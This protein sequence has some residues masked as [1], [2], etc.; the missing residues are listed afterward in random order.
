MAT[1]SAGRNPLSH[2]AAAL[3]AALALVPG[4]CSADAYRRSADREVE[5]ILAGRVKS[6]RDRRD[7]TMLF[8][9]EARNGEES[10]ASPGGE[11]RPSPVVVPAVMTIDDALSVAAQ[12]NREYVSRRESLYLSGLALS[13]ARF[14]FSPQFGAT[15]SYVS[16]DASGIEPVDTSLGTVTASQILPTGGTVSASASAGGLLDRNTNGDF[17]TGT[18]VDA[19]LEQPLLR[20]AGYEVSHE[21]LTQAQRNVVYAIRDFARF[22]ESF[23]LD[24]T[25]RYYDIL[26][27]KTVLRN[28]EERYAAVEYQVRRAKALFD[29]G[30][31]DKIEVLRAERDLLTVQNELVNARDTLGFTVDQFKVFLGLPLSARFEI[32]EA[33]PVFRKVDVSLSSAV[34][35]AMANRFDLA[36]AREQLEDAERAVRIA[37]DALLPDLSFRA[38]TAA[39]SLQV[40]SLLDHAYD[41]RANSVGLF[42]EIPLQQTL[43]RNALRSAQIS[44]DAERRSY[45]EFRDNMIVEVRET[46]RR[47][48]QAAVSLEIQANQIALSQKLYEKAQI[49]FD[50]GRIG[51]RDLLEAQQSLT[52]ARNERIQRVVQYELARI[53]LERS[54]GTL[55][56]EPDGSWRVRRAPATAGAGRD[57]K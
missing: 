42:L 31:Q 52:D 53:N 30:K 45:E 48:R 24:V 46:L 38:S 43:E 36:N 55:E 32:A 51:N 40:S 17:R 9:E 35:A 5:D 34:A 54:M 33:E 50:A 37:A 11:D 20:G 56:V 28:T 1:P 22:R 49:D 41:Q 18:D 7:S 19:S 27:Q 10:S 21:S 3:A 13:S 44:L 16:R 47:L 2:R 14:R 26:S 8:P 25:R 12:A 57:G 15:L 39:S 23:L 29:I 4:G 6:L